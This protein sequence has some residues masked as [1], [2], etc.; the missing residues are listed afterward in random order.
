MK[1]L[2]QQ[3]ARP[4]VLTACAAPA[5][6]PIFDAG[7]IMIVNTSGSNLTINSIGVTINGSGRPKAIDGAREAAERNARPASMQERLVHIELWDYDLRRGRGLNG[8]RT[9]TPVGSKDQGR[10]RQSARNPTRCAS[11]R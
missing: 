3:L 1:S 10:G 5:F 2:P 4:L 6:S 9:G 11:P 7:A 8:S